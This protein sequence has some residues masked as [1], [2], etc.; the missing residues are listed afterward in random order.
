[1]TSTL[2]E[3]LGFTS[4][5]DAIT[6]FLSPV[7][8]SDRMMPGS[9]IENRGLS[10]VTIVMPAFNA[11]STIRDSIKS[12]QKQT[13][14]NWSLLVIDDGSFDRTADIVRGLS[15]AD[16][17]I[18]LLSRDHAGLCAALN[19]GLEAAETDVIARLDADDLWAEQH[20]ERQFS[21]WADHRESPVIGTWGSRINVRGERISK[22]IVGPS[23]LAEYEEQMASGTPIYLIHSS[24]LALRRALL[25]QGGYREQ[26]HPAEDVHLW[27]RIARTNP[28]LAI[29]EDLTC[30]RM[31]GSGVSAGA[32]KLQAVQTERLKHFLR[33]GEEL[34]LESF[35]VYLRSHPLERLR[36]ELTTRQRYWFRKGASY[37]QNGN[38]FKGAGYVALSALLNPGLVAR[39]IWH[40]V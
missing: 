15:L 34:G 14:K 32:F 16:H 8:G 5:C 28:V 35:Q 33:T 13:V 38:R 10:R 37:A 19:A 4:D 30:Y 7:V 9:H 20:L 11:E 24:V 39:R 31:S 1:M 3:G 29:P 23:T 18:R 21:F 17:R 2:F 27:T 22:L 6:L 40:S 36:F 12:V 26:E 25:D